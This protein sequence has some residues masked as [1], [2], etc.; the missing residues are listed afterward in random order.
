MQ[1]DHFRCKIP[2][3]DS[4]A[5]LGFDDVPSSIYPLDDD[6]D[7]DYCKYYPPQRN[8][9]AGECSLPS[10]FDFTASPLECETKEGNYIYDDFEMDD[11]V[12]TEWDLVCDDEFKVLPMQNCC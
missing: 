5:S 3:C 2:A 8:V 9:T 10:N 11:T 7:E 12:V 6:D 1:P 4:G